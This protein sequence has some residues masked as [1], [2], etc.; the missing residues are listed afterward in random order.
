MEGV[1][2]NIVQQKRKREQRQGYTNPVTRIYVL[3]PSQIV[4]L[5]IKW[6]GYRWTQRS[7]KTVAPAYRCTIRLQPHSKTTLGKVKNINT[8]TKDEERMNMKCPE[9]NLRH[10]THQA[11]HQPDLHAPIVAATPS[12]EKPISPS[13]DLPS[14]RRNRKRSLAHLAPSTITKHQDAG[15]DALWLIYSLVDGQR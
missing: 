4:L 9:R 15:R 11:S 2:S 13:D 8:A 7:V 1:S 10:Q 12:I 6:S 3:H 14:K 5:I